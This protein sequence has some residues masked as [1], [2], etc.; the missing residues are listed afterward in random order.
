MTMSA[1]CFH[2]QQA[3]NGAGPEIK[4]SQEYPHSTTEYENLWQQYSIIGDVDPE[5]E[6]QRK[7]GEA[8]NDMSAATAGHFHVQQALN[9]TG[10]EIKSSRKDSHSTTEL[11]QNLRQQYGSIGVVD[12]EQKYQRKGREAENDMSAATAG[13]FHVQQALNGTGSEIKPSRKDSHSTTE[14][15]QN[16]QQQYGLIGGVDCEQ[17]Y[18]RK[19][20]E[21]EDDIS[22]QQAVNRAG[23]IRPSQENRHSTT[24]FEQKLWQQY[25]LVGDVD[26]EHLLK[27]CQR[28]AREAVDDQQQ[29]VMLT[30]SALDAIHEV[31]K[32]SSHS[33][34]L[35]QE[36]IW[37]ETEETPPDDQSKAVGQHFWAVL[38]GNNKYNAAKDLH[39]ER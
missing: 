23:G 15:E 12:C 24:G 22:V 10:P 21:A 39:G 7:G 2:V 5:Q 17:K 6:Y 16:L 13:H 11:E 1:G 32:Q 34:I 25:G 4:P 20:T 26:P 3:M 31:R 19:G 8:E 36:G 28:R 37:P 18:Q 38:I 29:I 30:L 9:G 14:L 35:S 33:V 27:E